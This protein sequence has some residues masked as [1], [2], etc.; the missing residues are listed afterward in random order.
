M[1]ATRWKFHVRGTYCRDG[2]AVSPC[3]A[4]IESGD[5]LH[6]SPF[7]FRGVGPVAKADEEGSFRSWYV[8]DGSSGAIATPPS[9]SVYV[10]VG[11][12]DWEPIVVPIAVDRA[13]VLSDSE[14]Q[15]DLGS[16]TIPASM[17]PYAQDA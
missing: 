17:T 4:I 16:V 12:G 5:R 2:R 14:M 9:V 15:L 10:R 1:N 6:G 11:K 3:E 13:T 7:R 8:T